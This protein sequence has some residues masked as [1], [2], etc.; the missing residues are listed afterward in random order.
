MD[1]PVFTFSIFEA[2]GHLLSEKKFFLSY[3]NFYRLLARVRLSNCF[4][5]KT[6]AIPYCFGHHPATCGIREK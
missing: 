4:L 6:R 2:R 3:G 5:P 1:H